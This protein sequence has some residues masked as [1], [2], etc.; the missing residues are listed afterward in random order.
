MPGSRKS[1]I[2]KLMPIFVEV[3]KRLA[4]IPAILVI[5]ASFSDEKISSWYEGKELFEIQRDTHKALSQAEFAFICS[6]TATLESALIGTAFVLAYIAKP[7]QPSFLP[8]HISV[9]SEV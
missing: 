7:N 8:P 6:G 1:E 5:P 9:L 2:S 3:R 4:N